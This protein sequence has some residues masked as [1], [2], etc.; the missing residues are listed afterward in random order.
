[1]I[2]ERPILFSAEM[3][4]LIFEGRKIQTRRMLYEEEAPNLYWFACSEDFPASSEALGQENEEDGLRIYT[5]EEPGE[6]SELIKCRYGNIG[7]K[8]IVED[9][10][11]TLEITGVSIER[12]HEISEE[13]AKA[14]GIYKATC[15]NGG[16]KFARGEQEFDT[17]KEAFQ[18]FW[19]FIYG[20]GSW[21]LSPWIW[22]ISFKI[23]NKENHDLT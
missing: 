9:Y 2:K 5:A 3:V 14:E 12:L 10:A 17:A 20:E 7:D 22:C 19:N 21:D 6:G 23:L 4:N 16:Y 15:E 11:I 18:N 13:D 8:L 1:M